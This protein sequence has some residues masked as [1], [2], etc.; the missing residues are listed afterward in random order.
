MAGTDGESRTSVVGKH[1]AGQLSSNSAG[2]SLASKE[3]Q[4]NADIVSPVRLAYQ[5]SS[6]EPDDVSEDLKKCRLIHN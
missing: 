1:G 5:H 4:Y 2:R 6:S 3:I